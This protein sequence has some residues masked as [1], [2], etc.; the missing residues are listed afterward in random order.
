LG[1]ELNVTSFRL[2]TVNDLD[3][4]WANPVE[5]ND[6][7]AYRY[8]A[9][10]WLRG[11]EA[12]WKNANI[13]FG[14]V[15]FLPGT[16]GGEFVKS[17]GQYH[18]VMAPNKAATPEI[19]TVLHGT[20]HFMLQKAAPPYQKIEDAILVKVKAG[21]TFVVPPDYGHLQINPTNEPLIFSYVVMDGMAGVYDPFKEMKGAMYYEMDAADESKRYIFNTNYPEKAPLRI[22]NAGDI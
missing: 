13:V 5:K 18:P 1:E 6:R 15:S 2:R 14:I 11:D 19:Y 9:G 12:V 16:Y 3:G 20:G 10:L 22:I 17:S 8:T 7:V 4:V 21:E